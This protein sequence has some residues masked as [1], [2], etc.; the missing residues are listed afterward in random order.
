L[1]VIDGRV[2]IGTTAPIR[3]LDI[4][5][6]SDPSIEITD[7][8]NTV[9]L[10]LTSFDDVASIGTRSNHDLSIVTNNAVKMRIDTAGLVG[11]GTTSPATLL[12]VKGKANFTG[13]FSVG[14]TSNILF[15]DNTSGRVGIGT[16]SPTQKLTVIG[17]ISIDDSSGDNEN[18]LIDSTNDVIRFTGENGSLLVG[19]V[20]PIPTLPVLSTINL[21]SP[22]VF[23]TLNL[24]A[25]IAP[26]AP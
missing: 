5:G 12:D 1:Y 22:E 25:V 7:T 23:T 2:G 9:E 8:T 20:V 13:N 3:L 16:R 24:S 21:T 6:A 19:L 10:K 4:E 15:V 26:L 11:I 18:I 17:N 14:E